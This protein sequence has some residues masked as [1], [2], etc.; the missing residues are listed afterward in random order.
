MLIR[1]LDAETTG[2]PSE[3]DCHALVEIGWTDVI[4]HRDSAII[5]R[6]VSHLINPGRPIPVEAMAVHH[7]KDKDVVNAPPPAEIF[8]MLM[9]GADMF[10]AHNIEFE[11]NFF[12]GGDKPWICTYKSALRIWPNAP[13][14]SNQELRYFR[15]Y[16]DGTDVFDPDLAMPPHRAGPDSY[17]TAFILSELLGLASMED[18]Q[19]WSSGPALLVKCLFGKHSGMLWKDVPV[20]YLRWVVDNILD[21]RDVRAT[22]NH[23]L[24]KH[25]IEKNV[26][27]SREKKAHDK[28]NPTLL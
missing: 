25:S 16:D 9:D 5:T 7:I 1:V 22:A 2:I 28:E 24:K 14:H 21:N 13:G 10:C 4:F 26:E 15:R 19:R 17:T 8:K 6:P 18:L 3:A 23:W 20:G 27:A 11:K 12:G